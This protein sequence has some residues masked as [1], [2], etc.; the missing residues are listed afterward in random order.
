MLAVDVVCLALTLGMLPATLVLTFLAR[1]P[2]TSASL[3]D[4]RTRIG[5][6][7]QS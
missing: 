4:A 1:K 7:E 6:P 5:S 3:L 2:I